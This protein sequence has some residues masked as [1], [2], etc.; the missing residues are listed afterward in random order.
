MNAGNFLEG[1]LQD[2]S[3]L[4]LAIQR[5]EDIVDSTDGIVWESDARTFVFSYVSAAAERILGFPVQQWYQ[6]GFWLAHLHPDDRDWA[7]KYCASCTGRLQNHDFEY[8]FIARDGRTVWLRDI[9]RVVSEDGAPRWL[10][11]VM[12]DIT[13]S[14]L[15]SQRCEMV[16]ASAMDGVLFVARDARILRCN[17]VMAKLTGYEMDEL[18]GLSI[19]TLET[20]ES[21]KDISQHMTHVIQ[22]GTHHFE[23]R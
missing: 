8:R 6:P 11:G 4:S 17:Q 5:F 12:V 22:R 20:L 14:K 1:P 7:A 16:I 10:R 18:P 19:M 3:K 23:S 2:G 15:T 13:E 9:V 21:A